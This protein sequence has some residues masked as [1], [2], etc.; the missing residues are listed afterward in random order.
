MERQG[1]RDTA[2]DQRTQ[3]FIDQVH[4]SLGKMRLGYRA[5]V[6]YNRSRPCDSIHLEE[7]EEDEEEEEEEEKTKKKHRFKCV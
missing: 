3:T 2:S 1:E 5:D 6:A 7:D 4:Q